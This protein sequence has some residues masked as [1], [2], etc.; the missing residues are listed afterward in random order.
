MTSVKRK[1][2]CSSGAFLISPCEGGSAMKHW[3]QLT[4]TLRGSSPGPGDLAA[5]GGVRLEG[6]DVLRIGLG[7]AHGRP[8]ARVVLELADLEGERSA[9]EVTVAGLLRRV[10]DLG[11]ED[12]VLADLDVRRRG[13]D[14][15]AEFVVRAA[16]ARSVGAVPLARLGRGRRTLHRRLPRRGDLPRRGGVLRVSPVTAEGEQRD[17]HGDDDH[18]DQRRHSAPHVDFAWKWTLR[19]EHDPETI[20]TCVLTGRGTP[21]PHRFRRARELRGATK[22]TGGV[23]ARRVP[24][25]TTPLRSRAAPGTR[26][27]RR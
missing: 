7:V 9:G 2:R 18:G 17:H 25:R 10:G 4:L 6:H 19:F 20:S 5:L 21:P 1:S 26:R 24:P 14:G 23:L 8:D 15:D 22:A 11:V 12:H 16:A 27:Y 3:S 13:L